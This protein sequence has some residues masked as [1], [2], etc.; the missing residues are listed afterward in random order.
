[1]IISLM[2]GSIT[3]IVTMSI[4]VAFV[5][6]LIRY[7]IRVMARDGG[8]QH[9]IGFDVVVISTVMLLLFAGHMSQIAIWAVLFSYLNEFDQFS[10][11]FYHSAVNFSSL[12]YGDIV[13]SERWR[14]LGALEA[15]NGVLM[16]GL[17]TGTIFSIMSQLFS[18]R[19]PDGLQLSRKK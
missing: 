18:I 7:L 19:R 9:G 1:M 10:T 6:M 8:C 3:V 4:Q 14:L 11:A 16:F 5:V 12:G 2:L 13:M 17:S 15:G